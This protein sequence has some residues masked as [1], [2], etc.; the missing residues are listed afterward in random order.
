MNGISTS[1]INKVNA[2][3]RIAEH[4]I[5]AETGVKMR[6]MIAPQI[7]G[8]NELVDPYDLLSVV[9]NS[10]GMLPTDYQYKSR[11]RQYVTLRMLGAYFLKVN[12]R[13]L[14]LQQIADLIGYKEHSMVMHCLETVQNY[15]DTQDKIFMY[16]YNKALNAV[17][18]WL[19]M[20]E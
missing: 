3:I 9:A 8:E 17:T 2:I 4:D 12:R 6:L 14:S 11:Q 15:M 5:Y 16:S 10:L 19:E 1:K 13:D 20:V 18:Q 7:T